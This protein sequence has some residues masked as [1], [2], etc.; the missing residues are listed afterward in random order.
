M[1]LLSYR[2]LGGSMGEIKEVFR[3]F[4]INRK[5]NFRFLSLNKGSK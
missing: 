3:L 1:F 5:E 2:K 4:N